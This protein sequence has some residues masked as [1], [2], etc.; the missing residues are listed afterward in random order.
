M[1]PLMQVEA[2][3]RAAGAAR[4][5]RSAAAQR[6]AGRRA[7]RRRHQHS[8]R[9]PRSRRARFRE[10]LYYRLNVVTIELPPLRDRPEDIPLLVHHFAQRFARADERPPIEL[11]PAALDALSTTPGRG[12]CASSRTRSC[13]SRR[14]MPASGWARPSSR[15]GCAARS[16]CGRPGRAPRGASSRPR[17]RLSSVRSSPSASCASPATS[18][19]RRATSVSP[20]RVWPRRCAGTRSAGSPRGGCTAGAAVETVAAQPPAAFFP[21][22]PE[23]GPAAATA[24]ARRPPG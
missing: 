20:G 2:P 18:R 11:A 19:A 22:E 9:G 23:A 15:S 16:S 7:H 8:P 24:T 1:R 21:A 6:V 14:S 5:G 3:P 4:S 10:D 12:T 13:A 17:S